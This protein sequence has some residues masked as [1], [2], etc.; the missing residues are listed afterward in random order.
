[1]WSKQ[2]ITTSNPQNWWKLSKITISPK[3]NSSSSFSRNTPTT[4]ISRLNF[5]KAV[6]G[7]FKTESSTKC[8]HLPRLTQTVTPATLLPARH[9]KK[10]Y[11]EGF[12]QLL[13][14]WLGSHLWSVR[15]RSWED[16]VYSWWARGRKLAVRTSQLYTSSNPHLMNPGAKW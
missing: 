3:N 7:R 12:L 2:L 13:Y 6:W 8:D 1:M 5:S 14:S 15:K 11:S 9:S 10:D 4:P 16:T